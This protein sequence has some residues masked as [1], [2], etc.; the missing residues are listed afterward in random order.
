MTDLLQ[1]P[2]GHPLSSFSGYGHYHEDYR[3]EGEWRIASVYLSRLLKIEYPN[4]DATRIS[5][6][7]ASH[8]PTDER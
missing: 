6:H 7:F 5:R 3:K 8:I 1:R 4:L 2:P